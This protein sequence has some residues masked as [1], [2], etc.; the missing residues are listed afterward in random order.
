MAL[1]V[2]NFSKFM[3]KKG[4]KSRKRRDNFKNKDQVRRCFRCKSKDHILAD[5][6][7][8]SDNEED[9][10]KK[11]KEKEKKEKK[12]SFKKKK[13]K[14]GGSY[15]VTWDSD[16]SLDSDESSDDEKTSKKKALA[17]ITV[18]NKPSLFETPSCFMAKSSKVKYDESDGD[19]CESGDCGTVNDE[20]YSKEV[21]MDMME[22][23][24]ECLE[25]KS[26]ECKDLCKKYKSLEQTFDELNATH[27][28]L[29]EAHEKLGKAHSK[30]EKAHSS[31][32]EKDKHKHYYFHLIY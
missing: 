3:K 25:L 11:E 19:D 18:N 16:A 15:V 10:K 8:N 17:S 24:H 6:P 28:R 9:E 2:K 23:A 13:K 26:K 7:Y 21:L 14:I 29:M 22:Q 30:L 31:L 32:L 20:E 5:C 1:F 27:K 4:Y 12:M